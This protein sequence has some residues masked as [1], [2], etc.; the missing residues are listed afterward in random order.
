MYSA[1]MIGEDAKNQHSATR[2]RLCCK[3]SDGSS[4]GKRMHRQSSVHS[5][6]NFHCMGLPIP[7]NSLLSRCVVIAANL[8]YTAVP[9]TATQFPCQICGCVSS[10]LSG[11][12]EALLKICRESSLE[13]ESVFLLKR[14]IIV[15]IEEDRSN[16]VVIGI[17][18]L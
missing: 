5:V 13:M 16:I 17:R 4:A 7:C 2:E 10:V 15:E 1:R 9:A 8:S 3:C 12:A 6:V 18:G 11:G 14:I